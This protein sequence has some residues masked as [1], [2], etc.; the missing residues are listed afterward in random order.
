MGVIKVGDVVKVVGIVGVDEALIFM[1]QSVNALGYTLG[2][3]DGSDYSVGPVPLENMVLVCPKDDVALRLRGVS[4]L[5][6]VYDGSLDL[7]RLLQGYEGAE[8][9]SPLFGPV[10]LR[11]VSAAPL[12]ATEKCPNFPIEV[13]TAQGDLVRFMSDGR[14]VA[15]LRSCCML[16]PSPDV[17]SWK[18]WKVK[19]WR[20]KFGATYFCITTTGTVIGSAED[21][22]TVDDG[23]WEI[24]N[25]FQ[26]KSDAEAAA[27]LVIESLSSF[28]SE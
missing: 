19:R 20:A 9:W 10:E 13:R 7:V 24:G 5:W 17:L 2:A 12:S 28:K 8:L 23:R 26:K 25:Y 18:S 21:A 14:Y 27:Q 22:T 16:W 11:N 6:G 4:S 15:N 1:V 3:F